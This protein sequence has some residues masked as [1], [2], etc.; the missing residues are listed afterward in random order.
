MVGVSVAHRDYKGG[1]ALHWAAYYGCEYAVNFLL[2]FK[3]I[4][5]NCSDNEGFTPLHLAAMSGIL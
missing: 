1:T 4:D 5:I 2:S 3:E